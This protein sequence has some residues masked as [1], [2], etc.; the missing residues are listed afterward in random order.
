MKNLLFLYAI[1]IFF[2]IIEVLYI[3]QI[4][5][6]QLIVE[7]LKIQLLLLYTWIIYSS[8]KYLSLKV[9]SLYMLFLLT[10][11]LFIFSRIFMDIFDLYD[12]SYAGHMVDVQLYTGDQKEL[13][14][15]LLISLSCIHLGA[16]GASIVQFTKKQ[17]LSYDSNMEKIGTTLFFIGLPGAIIKSLIKLKYVFSHGYLALFSDNTAPLSYPFWTNISSLLFLI[18]FIF[19]LASLPSKRKTL[20]IISIFMSIVI[21]KLLGGTRGGAMV[22]FLFVVWYYYRFVSTKDIKVFLAIAVG[23]GL[24]ILSQFIGFFRSGIA[25]NI[26]NFSDTLI[27]FFSNMGT[28]LSVLSAMIHYKDEFINNGIPYIFNPFLTFFA[29]PSQGIERIENVPSLADQLSYFVAP[30]RYLSGEGVGTSFLG[31]LYDLGSLGFI[32]GNLLLGIFIIFFSK[33]V[34]SSRLALILSYH[35]VTGIIWMPR[36]GYFPPIIMLIVVLIAYFIYICYIFLKT[37]IKVKV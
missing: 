24:I 35:I 25:Y 33:I 6:D 22:I 4:E 17:T 20:I 32:L 23:S 13:L 9:V 29:P 12:I 15:Y 16:I 14:I 11:G 21:L 31:E 10:L 7:W 19:I 3:S 27:E 28:S 1:Y 26:N 37:L 18:G 5:P 8:I 30:E 2:L 34:G 36:G